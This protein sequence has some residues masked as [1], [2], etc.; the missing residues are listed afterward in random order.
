LLESHISLESY[1]LLES[2]G[3]IIIVSEPW[4]QN[5]AQGHV[6]SL[7]D[8]VDMESDVITAD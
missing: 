8:I 2:Y 1:S 3:R 6:D 7:A 4:W 5:L